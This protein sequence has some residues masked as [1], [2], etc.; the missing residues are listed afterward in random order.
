MPWSLW[1]CKSYTVNVWHCLIGFSV[2]MTVMLDIVIILINQSVLQLLLQH[3]L[4]QRGHTPAGGT[5]D[6]QADTRITAPIILH[7]GSIPTF[8]SFLPN[9]HS[10]GCC[11]SAAILTRSEP[12]C[13]PSGSKTHCS[14]LSNLNFHYWHI[15]SHVGDLVSSWNKVNIATACE[16]IRWAPVLTNQLWR[17]WNDCLHCLPLFLSF[18]NTTFQKLNLFLLLLSPLERACLHHWICWTFPLSYLMN[19]TNPSPETFLKR[20]LQTVGLGPK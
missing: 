20:K 8:L 1:F 18:W 5:G 9:C 13:T 10:A 16:I 14:H 12:R 4:D 2:N 6:Q 15:V 3:I 11:V 17:N 19:V 7:Q